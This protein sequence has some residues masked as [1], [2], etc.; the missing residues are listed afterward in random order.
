MLSQVQD[1]IVGKTHVGFE[2]TLSAFDQLSGNLIAAYGYL[3]DVVPGNLFPKLGK[4]D[5]FAILGIGGEDLVETDE[6]R[7]QQDP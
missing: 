2:L 1:K 5:L 3:A 6:H 4:I 7:N